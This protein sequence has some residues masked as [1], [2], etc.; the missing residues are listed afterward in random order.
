MKKYNYMQ[1]KNERYFLPEWSF[2]SHYEAISSADLTNG[3][4]YSGLHLDLQ[5]REVTFFPFYGVCLP[6]CA[7]VLACMHM[8]GVCVCMCMCMIT[9]FWGNRVWPEHQFTSKAMFLVLKLPYPLIVALML[10]FASWETGEWP[11]NSSHS[12]CP[13]L[14]AAMG[15]TLALSTHSPFVATKLLGLSSGCLPRSCTG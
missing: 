8:W 15:F 14:F 10:H 12:S 1:L 3:L 9:L 2:K 6:G 4:H 13:H 11:Q 5:Q 7:Y